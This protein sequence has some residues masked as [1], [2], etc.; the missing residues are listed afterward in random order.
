MPE[1]NERIGLQEIARTLHLSYPKFNVEYSL[2]DRGQTVTVDLRHIDGKRIVST[3]TTQQLYEADHLYQLAAQTAR[4][5]DEFNEPPRANLLGAIS[6]K[7][8]LHRLRFELD[9]ENAEAES[10]IG[11]RSPSIDEPSGYQYDPE[12]IE[13]I[14]GQARLRPGQREGTIRLSNLDLS[15]QPFGA[16]FI[17]L[18]RNGRIPDDYFPDAVDMET[19]RANQEEDSDASSFGSMTYRGQWSPLSNTQGLGSGGAGGQAGDY[20]IVSDDGYYNID[21]G[22]EW[23]IGDYIINDGRQWRRIDNTANMEHVN[24]STQGLVPIRRVRAV[25]L[26]DVIISTEPEIGEDL[27]DDDRKVDI[28]DDEDDDDPFFSGRKIDL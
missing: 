18:D 4:L 15:R 19:E 14:G 2:R 24:T 27:F 6:T 22:R 17:Q 7:F 11:N 1:N 20:Y 21:D 8:K 26:H 23:R 12:R 13:I 5:W 9:A 28:G 10:E 16:N 3:W 25:N